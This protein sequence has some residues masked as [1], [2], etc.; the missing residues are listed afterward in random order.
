MQSWCGEYTLTSGDLGLTWVDLGRLGRGRPGQTAAMMDL[1]GPHSTPTSPAHRVSTAKRLEGVV[2]PITT[3]ITGVMENQ[4]IK[5]RI[6]AINSFYFLLKL[7]YIS[8]FCI[9]LFYF[10]VS[11][12]RPERFASSFDILH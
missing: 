11:A 8:T 4:K 9:N 3:P 7:K 5:N 6:S 10:F 12:T 2:I 1:E